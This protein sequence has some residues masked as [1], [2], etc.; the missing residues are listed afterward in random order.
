MRWEDI[1]GYVLIGLLCIPII[2]IFVNKERRRRFI[3]YLHYLPEILDEAIE[4]QIERIHYSNNR[5]KM[6]CLSCKHYFPDMSSDDDMGCRKGAEVKR[7]CIL[8]DYKE[9]E[10]ENAA[11]NL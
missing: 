10:E 3:E 7:S 1:L 2:Y 11:E 9:R 6:L 5:Q 8:N 4:R